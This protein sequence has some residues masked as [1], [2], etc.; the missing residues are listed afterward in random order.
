MLG[1]VDL[2]LKVEVMLQHVLSA[3]VDRREGD[4]HIEFA[5]SLFVNLERWPLEG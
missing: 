4:N 1:F 2:L 5:P 3:F